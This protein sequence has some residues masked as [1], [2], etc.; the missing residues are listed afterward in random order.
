MKIKNGTV[1]LDLAMGASMSTSGLYSSY[2]EKNGTNVRIPNL[3]LIDLYTILEH[4]LQ[5]DGHTIAELNADL[6]RRNTEGAYDA[7]Q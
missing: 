4:R 3:L 5:S 1:Q 2:T 7:D 6:M